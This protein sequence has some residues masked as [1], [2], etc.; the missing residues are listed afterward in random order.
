[1]SKAH[2]N[3]KGHHGES[4]GEHDGSGIACQIIKLIDMTSTC[5]LNEVQQKVDCC[6]A[7]AR[8]KPDLA[9]SQQQNAH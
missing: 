7:H 4:G 3:H 9:P 1:M 8:K 5:H 2:K 6:Y